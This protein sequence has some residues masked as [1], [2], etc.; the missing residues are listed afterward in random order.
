M[1]SDQHIKEQTQNNFGLSIN[2]SCSG[3]NSIRYFSHFHDADNLKSINF[4]ITILLQN[5]IYEI[6][7]SDEICSIIFQLKFF[8]MLINI[9]KIN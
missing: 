2:M 8:L 5:K 9:E 7:P 1:H 6:T 3:K 4:F